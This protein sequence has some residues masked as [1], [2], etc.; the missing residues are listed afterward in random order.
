MLYKEA[1]NNSTVI[2]IS[3]PLSTHPVYKQQD[4][5]F[6]S[7]KTKSKEIVS[8]SQPVTHSHMTKLPLSH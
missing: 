3:L 4:S 8:L 5:T 7:F 6:L 2:V 1:M